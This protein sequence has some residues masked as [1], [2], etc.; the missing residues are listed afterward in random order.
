M[1]ESEGYLLLSTIPKEPAEFS[2]TVHGTGTKAELLS[3]RLVSHL[4]MEVIKAVVA[5]EA[6]P[7]KS[8]LGQVVIDT[9]SS[10]IPHDEKYIP[11][12]RFVSWRKIAITLI[13]P[14]SLSTRTT[15]IA[16]LSC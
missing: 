14:A 4:D 15:L 3:A 1:S 8:Y 5:I 16:S 6:Q 12:F 13:D 7:D 9:N 11:Q 2:E 10:T